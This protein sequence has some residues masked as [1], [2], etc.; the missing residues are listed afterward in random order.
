MTATF[1][2]RNIDPAAANAIHDDDVARQFGFTG[3]LVPGVELFARTASALV[4]EHGA[5]F[6]TGGRLALRFRRPVYDG[7]TVR[8]EQ[9]ASGALV[10]RGPDDEAR[11]IGLTGRSARREDPLPW[12]VRPLPSHLPPALAAS[13]PPGSLGTISGPLD[14]A[15]NDTYVTQIGDPLPLWRRQGLVHPGLL[16]RAV[17]LVLMRNVDLGPW[18]HTASDAH[19]LSPARVG[20]AME[21]RAVVRSTSVRNGRDEVRYDALVLADGVPV[22]VVEHTALFRL[23]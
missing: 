10:L 9:D 19:L 8:I 14:P 2:A 5:E 15:A 23:G 3:A 21:V 1:V 4:A 22:M 17:N 13:L 20:S 6:L 18:I 7:E 11:S 12:P 16:L